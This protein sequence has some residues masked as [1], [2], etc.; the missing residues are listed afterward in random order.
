MSHVGKPAACEAIGTQVELRDGG[1]RKGGLQYGEGA[2][3][4]ERVVC[5]AKVSYRA[6]D[7]KGFAKSVHSEGE[8]QIRREWRLCWR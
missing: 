1:T 7:G 2:M 8:A 5:E 6:V 4:A 3:V